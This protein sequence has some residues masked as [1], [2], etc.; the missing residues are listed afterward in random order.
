M[1]P[2]V[3]TEIESSLP[4]GATFWT[5]SDEDLGSDEGFGFFRDVWL[6][7][8]VSADEAE[9]ILRSE[10]DLVSAVDELARDPVEF[11]QIAKAIEEGDR[12]HLPER[13]QTMSMKGPIQTCLE[14]KESTLE[15]LEL[16]VAGLVYAL[17]SV[18]CFPAASELTS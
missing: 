9:A 11:D 7:F 12:E 15:G 16:G 2:R 6:I 8:D 14:H 3:D 5:P 1:I 10:A 4:E 13:L 18:G 17:A